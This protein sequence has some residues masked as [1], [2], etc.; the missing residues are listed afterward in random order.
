MYEDLKKALNEDG[1]D[2]EPYVYKYPE[3]ELDEKDNVLKEV[4]EDSD[5]TVAKKVVTKNKKSISSVIITILCV[6]FLAGIGVLTVMILPAFQKSKSETIPDVSNL[7]IQNA[8]K[9]LTNLDF[10]VEDK[11]KNE[12]VRVA[13]RCLK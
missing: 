1:T 7:T 3:H 11:H 6:I 13:K 10:I 8:E 4:K 9:A 5:E 2:V 12:W